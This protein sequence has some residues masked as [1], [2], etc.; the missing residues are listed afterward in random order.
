MPDINRLILK[1][2]FR[3]VGSVYCFIFGRCWTV[4]GWR[5]RKLFRLGWRSW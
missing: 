1:D 4:L 2:I 5:C 3:K